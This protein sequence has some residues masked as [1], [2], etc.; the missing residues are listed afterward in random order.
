MNSFSVSIIVVFLLQLSPNLECGTL[1][2][3][4][5][6]YRIY[7]YDDNEEPI[8]DIFLVQDHEW[9]SVDTNVM[10]LTDIGTGDIYTFDVS[11]QTLTKIINLPSSDK[12][13]QV[14]LSPDREYLVYAL[15]AENELNSGVY[16][17]SFRDKRSLRLEGISS[18][19]NGES[20]KWADNDS[21]I[22][23]Q[24]ERN[25]LEPE[26]I[27]R[28]WNVKQGS[29]IVENISFRFEICST[30]T[31]Y[32]NPRVVNDIYVFSAGCGGET[33]EVWQYDYSQSPELV[34]MSDSNLDDEGVQGLAVSPDGQTI[35]YIATSSLNGT[36]IYIQPLNS[37]GQPSPTAITF[38]E[39]FVSYADLE[40]QA[41][42]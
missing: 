34:T 32:N 9:S 36:N 13:Q 5:D 20:V 17:Y 2:Y 40:W 23:V 3:I 28:Y 37:N 11:Q 15:R 41:C 12:A 30:G 4:G 6:D 27:Y 35:G 22:L 21:V 29:P 38:G 26:N 39:D 8:F 18:P 19:P 24:S 33:N 31:F 7:S 42:N 10:I 25:P 1:T 16:L 14:S